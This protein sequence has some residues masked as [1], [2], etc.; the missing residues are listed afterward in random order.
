[1]DLLH[2]LL[3][4]LSEQDKYLLRKKYSKSTT[5]H[6]KLLGLLLDMPVPDEKRLMAA[7]D[8]TANTFHKTCTLAKNI[9]IEYIG[10]EINTGFDEI[11]IIK[12]LANRMQ[13]VPA[14]RY[15]NYLEKEYENI[16][17]WQALELLC[18]EG[19]RLSHISGD[20]TKAR[21]VAKK[22]LANSV[23][24]FDFI[25]LSVE[26]NTHLLTLESF[27]NRKPSPD[28]LKNITGLNK[29]TEQLGHAALVHNSLNLLFLY[30]S[31]H[32]DLD[33]RVAEIAERIRDNAEK[34]QHK[35]SGTRYYLAMNTYV[36]FLTIYAGFGEPEKYAQ[37]LKKKIKG[38]GNIALAN[39][40]YAM[41]EYC[42]H[43][44]SKK[45]TDAWLTELDKADDRSK[46]SQYRYG[47]LAMRDFSENDLKGFKENLKRFYSD[48]SYSGFPDMETT[49]RILELLMML[50]EKAF[51]LAETKLNSLRVYMDRNLDKKRYAQE[52]IIMQAIA[53]YVKNQSAE[54]VHRALLPLQ[55]SSYRNIRFLAEMLE[56][57]IGIK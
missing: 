44:F 7:L 55:N 42:I 47:I 19:T 3:L 17:N 35:L 18:I 49:L 36:I 38:E 5:L 13:T 24:L 27:S 26:L 8:T 6:E 46:F 53:A 20:I 29:K 10:K 45:E 21:A 50:Q 31:R 23:R 54:K 25:N 43:T 15:Y 16:Q 51:Y 4:L 40:C 2:S 33:A 32:S 14:I 48:P 12:E 52:R 28:F 56:R 30:Y 22:R 41:L 37:Q 57:S 1:M 39:L 11:F 34:N 9:L